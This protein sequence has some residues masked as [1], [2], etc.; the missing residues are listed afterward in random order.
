MFEDAL[1]QVVRDVTMMV[2]MPM[3]LLQSTFDIPVA[4]TFCFILQLLGSLQQEMGLLLLGQPGSVAFSR[5]LVN[6]LQDSLPLVK[7][8][9][10]CLAQMV[11]FA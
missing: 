3:C 9:V 11:L 7:Q 6:A 1:Q 5:L 8:H 4:V 2:L 10:A